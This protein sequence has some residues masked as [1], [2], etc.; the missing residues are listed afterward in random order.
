MTSEMPVRDRSTNPRGFREECRQQWRILSFQDEVAILSETRL[1]GEAKQERGMLHGKFR[2][3]W[4][5]VSRWLSDAVVGDHYFLLGFA[6]VVLSELWSQ[7]LVLH[8][9]RTTASVFLQPV[10]FWR[11]CESRMQPWTKRWQLLS[12]LRGQRNLLCFLRR[13]PPML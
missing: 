13:V 9:L 12:I 8:L 5:P 3:L 6:D 11:Y 10:A 1:S 2:S 7:R 4:C